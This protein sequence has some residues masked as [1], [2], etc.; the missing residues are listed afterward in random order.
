M[1]WGTFNPVTWTV[2]FIFAFL[3][4]ALLENLV[5]KLFFKLPFTRRTFGWLAVANA[6]SVSFAYISLWVKPIQP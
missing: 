1:N 6:I 3:I 4:N 2:T 5:L